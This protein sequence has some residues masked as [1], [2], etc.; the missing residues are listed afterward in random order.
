MRKSNLKWAVTFVIVLVFSAVGFYL[1]IQKDHSLVENHS[2]NEE[3]EQASH[4]SSEEHH[5]NSRQS[6]ESARLSGTVENGHRIIEITARQFEFVPSDIVVKEGDS[7]KLNVTSEDVTHGIEI[8]GYNINE[9]LEP[10][11]TRSITFQADKPGTFHFHC[12]VYCGDGHSQMH[13]EM[14]VIE[15]Q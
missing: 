12:S 7:V 9:T 13:G 5:N 10:D 11:Q 6:G 8:E 3:Q 14:R 2:H 1:F 15:K 4:N